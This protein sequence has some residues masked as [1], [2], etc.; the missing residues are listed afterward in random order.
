[1][2]YAVVG[3]G[4]IA[5][6]A[7]LPAFAHAKRNSRLVALVSG[8]ATKR[9]ELGEMYGV[10]FTYSYEEY[11][12]CVRSGEV[13]AVYI[14]L[15]N[16]QHRD[17]AVRAARAGVH[18]LCEKP[19]ACDEQECLE[20]IAAG[21]QNRV[22]LMTAYRLHFEQATLSALDKVAKGEIG[23]PRLFVSSFTMNVRPPNIRLDAELGGG[24]LYD[25]GIYCINA[26]R[27]IFRAEPVE[28]FAMSASKPE[29][30]FAEVEESMSATLRFPGERLATF[31]VSFGA[32]KT[33]EYRVV[34]TEG[35][36]RVEPA[37]ELADGLEH[38]LTHGK[39]TRHAHFDKRDQF[40]PE[41]L[42]FSDCILEDREPEPSG[43][44]GLA[45]VRVIKALYR[46]ARL[47]RP[48]KLAARRLKRQPTLEQSIRRPPVRRMPRLVNATPPAG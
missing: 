46:S 40:A 37:Y 33:S 18:V 24:T 15:P 16:S 28:V 12:R 19:L 41:I 21:R 26:A 11:D 43:E 8:D 14:A 6:A 23:E 10:D 17:Y 7:V 29:R 3:Q 30:R 5:Q 35:S 38:H 31:V 39:K 32:D 25:I 36:L 2:R 4:Y 20:I 34:G 9:R 48:V 13:D 42:Y 22:K 27:H 45:D 44:E 1:V 47:N